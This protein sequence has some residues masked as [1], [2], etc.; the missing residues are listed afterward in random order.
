LAVLLFIEEFIIVIIV[1]VG[2]CLFLLVFVG[3]CWFLLVFVGFSS[4]THMVSNFV[5]DW[6]EKSQI[7]GLCPL[8]LKGSPVFVA[9]FLLDV[10]FGKYYVC[11]G[12]LMPVAAATKVI[13]LPP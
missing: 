4:Y 1:F 12:I 13:N 10:V 11:S 5:V 9:K 7:W 6:R 8:G 3:F 2:F